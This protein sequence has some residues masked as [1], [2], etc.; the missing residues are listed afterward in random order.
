MKTAINAC[1]PEVA[2]ID[3]L[4]TLYDVSE[5]IDSVI[6]LGE[7]V[8]IITIYTSYNCK[9]FTEDVNFYGYI[10]DGNG[11]FFKSNI[12]HSHLFYHEEYCFAEHAELCSNIEI[13]QNNSYSDF[14]MKAF[15]KYIHRMKIPKVETILSKNSHE[16]TQQKSFYEKYG[17][18]L[19]GGYKMYLHIKN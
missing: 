5:Q 12:L 11:K 1:R 7:T 10:Q 2:M 18:N 4:E 17:F 13:P 9:G 8:F 14:I 15:L 16:W 3:F 6:K 19:D